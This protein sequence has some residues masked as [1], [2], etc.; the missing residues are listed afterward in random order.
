MAIDV[1]EIDA[2]TG[3]VTERDFT[4]DELAQREADQAAAAQAE[5][6]RVAAEQVRDAARA[7]AVA[8]FKKLGFTDAEIA[9]LVLP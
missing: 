2:L 4:P 1:L 5:A 7:S 3:T 8:R 9:T 6:E